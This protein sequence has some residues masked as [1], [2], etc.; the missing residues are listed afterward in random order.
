MASSLSNPMAHQT[1][2]SSRT[3]GLKCISQI[4]LYRSTGIDDRKQHV[5]IIG[6]VT[7]SFP[8][9]YGFHNRGREALT[10]LCSVVKH[11]ESNWST[12]EEQGETLMVVECF[13]PLLECFLSQDFSI[14]FIVKNPFS[15]P[16]ITFNFQS[17]VYF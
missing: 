2:L 6:P 17:R 16:R 15:S 12:K 10:V 11:V 7:F 13:S 4:P 3:Q 8:A 14:S 5:R 1:T 9:V